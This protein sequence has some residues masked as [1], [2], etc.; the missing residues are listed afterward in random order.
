MAV[1]VELCGLPGAGKSTLARAL[2]ARLRLAGVPTADVMAPLGPDAGRAGR[3]V[4][5]AV[6]AA[7]GLVEPGVGVVTA[8]AGQRDPR[9][10]VARPGNLLVVRHALRRSRRRQGVAVFDQGPVQEWWSA[11][12]RARD[13]EGVLA[14]A[15][16][17]PVPRADVL[18]RVDAPV[19]VLVERLERRAVRQS[20]L[21]A[22]DRDELRAVLGEGSELL[23]RLT[24]RRSVAGGAREGG[25]IVV[26]GLDPAAVQ[27]VAD[28][29]G[30]VLAPRAS[31]GDRTS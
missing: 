4:R 28:E 12:L 13:R 5:K 14:A 24:Q 9:D 15:A 7:V 19:E 25:P 11:A 20:R 17:D 18:V 6:A 21:E 10:L 2:V 31:S 8:A 30:R 3:L 29:V 22:L 23:D 27:R 16:A 1:V 26:D